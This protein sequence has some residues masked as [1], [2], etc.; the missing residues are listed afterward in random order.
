MVTRRTAATGRAHVVTGGGRGIG[1]AVTEALL[2]EG[3]SVVVVERDPDAVP[4]AESH[5]A[6]S[7][8]AVVTGSAAEERVA[9][10]AADRAEE[11]GRLVGWVNNAA[12]FRDAGLD[13][14]SAR[15][16]LDL[17]ELN[18]APALTGCATAVKRF[19]AAGSGGSIVNVSSHQAQR[20]VRG[21]L[22]YV[23]A[24]A[25]SRG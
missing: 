2:D 6:G 23:V 11:A 3:D 10:E 18:L 22:P 20:A 25:P 14:A 8:L 4:W 13:T 7:R 17:V 24:K 19:L 21:A 9:E 12:V 16:V 1:R 15:E 5:A